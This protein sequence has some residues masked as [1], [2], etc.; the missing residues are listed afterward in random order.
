MTYQPDTYGERI[1]ALYDVWVAPAADPL[2]DYTVA[3]L[4][5]LAREGSAL[6]LGIG[7]GRVALPLAERRVRVHGIDASEA[8]VA[9]LRA[10][11]GGGDFSFTVDRDSNPAAFG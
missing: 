11:P 3:F 4:A 9:Q 10:K 1:A 7:T 8:M 6:E 2:T 5:R